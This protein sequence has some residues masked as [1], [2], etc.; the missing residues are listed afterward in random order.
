[1]AFGDGGYLDNK[2]FTHAIAA[3][4][5]RRADFPVD[6]KLVYVEPAPEHP[7]RDPRRDGKPDAL[8]NVFA[9]LLELPRYETIR[10]DLESV[11]EL[12]RLVDRVGVVLGSR[13]YNSPH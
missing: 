8:E 13:D 3:L 9:A 7:E 1:M 10:E 11:E 2:P 12:N 6:R 4:K 5:R